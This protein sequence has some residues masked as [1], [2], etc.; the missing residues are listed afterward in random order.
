M[1]ETEE[2]GRDSTGTDQAG[3]PTRESSA[4]DTTSINPQEGPT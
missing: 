2:S 4:R 3:R 1:H